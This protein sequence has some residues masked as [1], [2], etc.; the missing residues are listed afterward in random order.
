MV[1]IHPSRRIDGEKRG[2]ASCSRDGE[3][4]VSKIFN[5]I[6]VSAGLED[7]FYLRGTASNF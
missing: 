2:S 4:R 7:D 3:D 6:C 5:I 1:F